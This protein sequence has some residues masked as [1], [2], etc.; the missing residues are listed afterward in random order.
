MNRDPEA[1]KRLGRLL[2]DAREGQGQTRKQF[3]E[4]AGVSEKAVY[5]AESGQVPSKQQPP[6]LVKIAAGHGWKPE[7][8]GIVLD[9]GEP[10]LASEPAAANVAPP[11]QELGDQPDLL[12]L[13]MRVHEFGRV[14]MALGGSLEARNAFEAAAQRLFESVPRETRVQQAHYGLAAYRPHALGEGV[15]EDDAEAIFRAMEGNQ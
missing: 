15:P 9:G 8:I 13:M 12:D 7:S 10:V 14:C 3:A 6:S 5:N 2:R 11:A 1:W 4:S